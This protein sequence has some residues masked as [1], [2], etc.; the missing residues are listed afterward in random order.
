MGL[1]FRRKYGVDFRAVRY[2]SIV[3]P[4][5]RT[6]GLAQYTSRVI[7]ECARGNPFTIWVKPET[8]CP[9]LYYKDAAR[10]IVELGE[11]PR[12]NIRMVNYVLAGVAPVASAGELAEM[13]EARLPDAEITFEPNLE[14]QHRLDQIFRPINDRKAQTE[15]GWKPEY[16]QERIVD[17][18][19]QE[20]KLN[21]QRY[22]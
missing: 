19:L 1:F 15:W 10:A 13:V 16:D 8:R 9:V 18:F 6:P 4:G 17:D 14:I 20:L 2:P 22:A 11:A 3:G 21:P 5:V 12:D 7:E